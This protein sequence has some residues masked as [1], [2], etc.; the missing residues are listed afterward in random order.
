MQQ[1]VAL[2]GW[3]A[4]AMLLATMTAGGAWAQSGSET[5]ERSYEASH[6]VVWGS[7][8]QGGGFI[9][10][11]FCNAEADGPSTGACLEYGSSYA[12]GEF[13]VTLTDAV[14]GQQTSFLV[15]FDLTGSDKID[16]THEDGGP[17]A[18]FFGSGTMNGTIPTD[19]ENPVLWVYP[20]TVHSS[21]LPCCPQSFATTGDIEIT[22]TQA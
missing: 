6:T 1:G 3:L 20:A 11:A 14:F 21:G 2:T 8:G 22:L 17:D 12:G 7:P 16:C 9:G 15:G 13:E 5:F 18:C 10:S 4:V 19:A